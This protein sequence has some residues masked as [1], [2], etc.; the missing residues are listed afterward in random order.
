MTET[1]FMSETA[2]DLAPHETS[3]FG[4]NMAAFRQYAPQ[5]HAHLAQTGKPLSRLFI[6]DDGTLDIIFGDRRLYGVD[7]VAFT[8]AQIDKYFKAPLRRYIDSILGIEEDSRGLEGK[9]KRALE[10][11][12]RAESVDL[13]PQRVSQASHF[14][15][16]F[17]LGLGLHL[18]PLVDFTQCAELI[19]IEPSFDNLY[20]SL[21]VIDWRALFEKA[22]RMGCAIHIVL[23]KDQGVISSRL[24][25]LI[26]KGSPTLIDGTY[27]YQHYRSGPLV[28]AQRAFHT[29]FGVHISGLGFF[30]DELTMI[31]NTVGNLKC[32]GIRIISKPQAVREEPVIICGSGPSI[33][34][35]LDVIAAQR[36][37]AIVVSIG[38]ALRILLAHGIRPD[39]HVEVENHPEN[40][41][42][43]QRAAA[44]F[45]LSGITLIASATVQT[46]M[47]ELFDEFL[48]YFRSG[49]SQTE[50][51]EAGNDKLDTTGPTVANAAIVTLMHLGFREICLFGIDMGT[52]KVDV[53]HSADTYIGLGKSYEWAGETRLPVAANFGGEA[54]AETI[55]NWSRFGIENVLQTQPDS[56]CINCSDG[57]RIAGAIP[58]LPEVFELPD[59]SIDQIAV[60]KDIYESMPVFAVE[61]TNRIWREADW[62]EMVDDIF[63][64][65]DRVL[66]EA[67]EQEQPDLNWIFRLFDS[68]DD[69]KAMSPTVAVFLFGT[70]CLYIGTY[71]WIDGRI[72]DE[73]ERYRLRRFAV[74]ELQSHYADM[75]QRMISLSND[76]GRCLAGEIPSV[77]FKMDV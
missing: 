51:F 13:A 36:G 35:C 69:V 58:M 66:S 30:E 1:S 27:A 14:T 50:L 20:H 39:F 43:A 5:I 49:Q 62:A 70:T 74:R 57:A 46:I 32:E 68:I 63:G 41:A 56:R 77:E 48:L 33:D 7:A 42:N 55:L 26:R 15:V 53:Y 6:D 64:L 73:E 40:A 34:R 12:L 72:A 16:V 29:E 24:R 76:V 23:E 47:T 4:E 28:E 52:R 31:A 38:S 17:G 8:Q 25:T 45:G 71:W 11:K 10:E 65:F 61:L 2:A 21:S 59:R 19:V 3:F 75:K 22:E 44:E 54:F 9:F 60:V 18:E 67:A 37:R